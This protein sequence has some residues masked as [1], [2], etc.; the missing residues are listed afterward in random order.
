MGWSLGT[1]AAL[2]Y[3]FVAPTANPKR[4]IGNL[5]LIATKP[6]GNT[7]GF[8]DGNEASCVMTLFDELKNNPDLDSSFKRE[9]DLDLFQLTFPYAG[10]TPN[11]G[12]NSGC[13]ATIGDNTATLNVTLNCPIDSE[14]DRNQLVQEAN[15]NTSP[16]SI[17]GG[18]DYSLFVQ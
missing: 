9:L 12:P 7:D 8:F 17:T 1:V 13:T 6:G 18:T 15:R 2:K 5:I 3:T 11:S 16:W 10:Q 14:C 4:K